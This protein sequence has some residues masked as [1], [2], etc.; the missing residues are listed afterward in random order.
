MSQFVI[1]D[2]STTK[3]IPLTTDCK[4]TL[5][6]ISF[7]YLALHFKS[8]NRKP[9]YYF[10]IAHTCYLSYLQGTPSTAMN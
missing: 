1:L 5:T 3:L 8:T 9:K 7:I 6:P 2:A 10:K 4:I